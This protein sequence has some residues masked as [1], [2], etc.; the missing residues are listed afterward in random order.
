M[1]IE[2]QHFHHVL[3]GTGQATGTLIAGLPDDESIAVIEGG[4]VG[5]TCVNVGCTPTKALVAAARVAQFARR[6][7]AYGVDV[8][9]VSVDFPAAMARMNEV[10][11]GSRDGLTRY[12]AQK[13]N[14]TL[15]RGWAAFT[16]PRTV[17]VGETLVRGEHVY[18]NVGARAVKP[19]IDGLDDVPWLDNA[20]VLDLDALPAHLVII[21]GSYI[22]LELGQ[23]FLRFGARVTVVEAGAR[24]LAREDA[25]VAD[26]VRQAL[27][28][29]GLTIEVGTGVRRVEPLGEGVRV[30]LADG[31]Q[32]DGSHLLVATGRRPNTDGLGLEA[33]GVATDDRGYVV[34][35]G[36]TRTSA[37]GVFALGDVNGRGA[38]THTSVHD[39]QVV[40]DHLQ[41]AHDPRTID[42]RPTVYALFTDPPLGRVGLTESQALAA[43]HRV[44]RAT[45]AMRTIS[46][47]KE[48]GETQGFVKVLVDADDD[49]FLGASVLGVGG[50]EIVNLFAVAMTAGMTTAQFRRAVLVHPTV[51]ELMPWVLAGL[52]PVE[53]A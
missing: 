22:A 47:A 35:D 13:P 21:G 31:R 43:G 38:F 3:V 33:A 49:R 16:A 5:G 2:P 48:M 28:A 17:R 53:A 6:A 9:N 50:D 29:E 26:G 34:V 12:L 27:E 37:E 51:S 32:V 23:V 40:L 36:R 10:R 8:G 30:E 39:A 7:G 52:Q 11:H 15:M 41:G 46:R 20:S 1:S 19:A 4:A 14:V 24:F 45:K 25:D 18:L 44:L 42:E